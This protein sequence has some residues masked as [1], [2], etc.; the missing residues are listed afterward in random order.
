MENLPLSWSTGTVVNFYSIKWEGG[1]GRGDNFQT[2]EELNIFAMLNHVQS[3][4]RVN[5]TFA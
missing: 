4:T 5:D 2:K 1:R 3:E